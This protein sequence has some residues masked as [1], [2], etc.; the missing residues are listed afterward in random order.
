MR[1]LA[2][3]AAWEDALQLRACSCEIGA[4]A[5][6]LGS[7]DQPTDSDQA[8]ITSFSSASAEMTSAHLS[9]RK[10]ITHGLCACAHG[11]WLVTRTHQEAFVQRPEGTL[12]HKLTKLLGVVAGWLG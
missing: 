12:L 6:L 11:R 1:A 10:T 3:S 5:W 2:E 4:A 7:P 8:S 9:C